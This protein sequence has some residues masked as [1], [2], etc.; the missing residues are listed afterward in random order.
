M[1]TIVVVWLASAVAA[2][3]PE[4]PAASPF[5]GTGLQGRPD[6]TPEERAELEALGDTVRRFEEQAADYREATRD[7]IERKYQEKRDL[8]FDSYERLI[9][10]LEVEQRKR[11][12]TAIAR[13][14]SFLERYP[15]DA[16]YTPD[17]MFRLSE[18]YFERSYDEYFQAR[19]SYDKLIETWTP[20]SGDPE[21]DEPVFHY[22]PTIGLMQRLITEFPGYR[23]VDGAYYLLGYCLGEQG[24]EERA[25]DVYVELVER[26][27]ASKFNAEVWTRI[28]EYYFAANELEL[29]LDAYTRVL[30]HYD[31]PFYDKAMYKL[32]W[33]HYRLA[34]PERSPAEFQKA[35]DT[36]VELLEFNEK[37]KAEGKERGGELRDES[38]QYIAICYADEQWGS[39]DKLAAF[40]DDKQEPP[41]E[42]EV[43]VA[44][45]D[46]YF[47][48]TRFADAVAA[49][50]LAQQRFG[51]HIEAPL[52]QEKLISAHERNRDFEGATG[53]RQM[54]SR[55]YSEGSSWYE[56]HKDNEE[57]LRNVTD[58]TRKS[59]YSAALFHHKQAQI[60]KKAEKIELAKASYEEAA[61][62][63]GDYL[64]RFPHDRQLY[65]LRFYYAESLYYSLQFEP[66]AEQYAL[67]RDS[68]TDDKLQEPA[69]FSVIL[70]YENLIKV[71]EG[72]GAL[73]KRPVLKS[74]DRPEG[75]AVE[76]QEIP[77]VKQELI[78]ASDRYTAVAPNDEKVPKVAYK[79]AEIFY[80]YD[81]IEEARRR[82]EAI[83]GTYPQHEVAEYAAN[84]IIETHLADKNFVAVEQFTR[85]LLDRPAAPGR[86]D[87]KGDLVKFKTGA[88]FKLAEDLDAKGEHEAAAEMYLKLIDENP[89]NQFADSALNNAAV[90]FERVK[91][92]ESASRLYE[93]LVREHPKSPLADTALFRV[94]LNAE[95][96][97]DFDKAIRSYESLVTRYPKS[98][99]RADAIYNVALSLEN[100]QKYER[101]AKEYLR[102]CKLFPKRDDAP[103]VCFRAG[104][105]YE[106]MGDQR[107]VVS[108]YQNYVKKY[109]KNTRYN[110]KIAEAYLK[111]GKTFDDMGRE[112]DAKRNY[113]LAVK[114]AAQ[115][116]DKA[117]SARHAAEAR[118][119]LVE[120]EFARFQ[121]LTIQ[122]SGKQQQRAL[123]KK[124]EKLKQV[125]TDY[126]GILAFKQVDWTLASLFRIGQL[127]QGF[128]ESIL[129]APCPV[130]VK[131]AARQGGWTVEEVCDQYR[132]ALED[133]AINVED[134]AVQAYETTINRARELQVANEWTHA[135]LVALNRLRASEWPLQKEARTFVDD[136]IVGAPPARSADGA[137]VSPLPEPTPPAAEPDEKPT[138][139]AESKPSAPGEGGEPEPASEP[140]PLE[141]T[142][143]EPTPLEPTPVGTAPAPPAVT[144]APAPEP[145]GLEATPVQPGPSGSR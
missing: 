84:L 43:I 36:F 97:F 124:A 126:K 112:R 49:Y 110:D 135:T 140:T 79:T 125:E 107:R 105:V 5:A 46:V 33:T 86:K 50:E 106:K 93:R 76:A 113:E 78:A 41:Y 132:V 72:S 89:G 99:R 24:E 45:G 56:Q 81:H 1:T 68:N 120:R 51:D 85:N 26:Y 92:Y 123:K 40:V 94:G 59:L 117:K 88:M 47:D 69:A 142:P 144:A 73:E 108:T 8:L 103:E 114:T 16:R 64:S 61:A 90:N 2:A 119:A 54:L 19:Q 111:M 9:V 116:T 95:R 37:T 75:Q 15:D 115:A 83:L 44:L 63:Y 6:Y 7:L 136:A 65:E 82:F 133:R 98:D 91:R 104:A 122:G 52:V 3:E 34:D 100:T 55:N 38:V 118:F 58:L 17:A 12:Y 30:G 29:A 138:P 67:V 53:A 42:R 74:T 4:E 28:G 31:S 60:H 14:E 130:D 62:A 25:V 20:E 22:E 143:L 121:T 11:R 48:Q 101:S 18:L 32:A 141:P 145:I 134:K 129:S 96:F 87:F 109:R 10:D 27:P 70:S 139:P 35:V 128:A 71:L 137:V 80:T 57:A 23:L 13:F 21:P 39:L 77:K 127:Y 131:R 66:A 102:Y